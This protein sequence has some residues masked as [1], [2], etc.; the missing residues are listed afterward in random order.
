MV[1]LIFI[2]GVARRSLPLVALLASGLTVALVLGEGALRFA[3][4]E[5]RT[6]PTVQFGWPEPQKIAESYVPDRDL[7]WVMRGYRRLLAQARRD[8]PA[9]VFL[10]DSCTQFGTYPE[11]T[12]A[13]LARVSPALSHGA[14]LG[15]AG[16]SSVQGLAQL[17]RDVL[18]L[19][20]QVVTIYF[21][22]NDHWMALG[23]PD[24]EA[25]PGALTWWLSQHS[26]LFQLLLKAR[27]TAR[28]RLDPRRPNRV[29]L[30]TYKANLRDMACL[31]HKAAIRPVFVT[32]AS[33]HEPG[34]EP[35]YLAGRHLRR[36]D[37]LVPLHGAYVEATREVARETGASLC[38]VAAAF[39][40]A[41]DQRHRY[42]KKDGIHLTEQGDEEL[43][44]LLASCIVDS[45]DPQ[46]VADA[47]GP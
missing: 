41:G 17:R 1:R 42:F 14:K 45:L 40:R 8:R 13:R 22:W 10:G 36:L 39:D 34:R 18:P 31:S 30:P 44:R 15:V 16:W 7:F 33:G 9:V 27:L 46:R 2:V 29:D 20:P 38:D 4:F 35:E 11:R 23:A 26:R 6:F 47:C 25:R 28:L 37:E 12:L 32:A 24:G 5:Y 3:G 21:G 43:A 19:R